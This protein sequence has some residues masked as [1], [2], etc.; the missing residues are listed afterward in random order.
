VAVVPL[1]FTAVVPV[2]LV[3]AMVTAVPRPPLLGLKLLIAGVTGKAVGLTAGPPGAVTVIVPVVAPA[4]TVAVI[5]VLE[6]TV[7]VV[8]EVPLKLTAVLPV[9]FVPLMV[10]TVPTGPLAGE[11]EVKVG[12]GA[13]LNV[14]VAAPPGVVTVNEPVT[15]PVG[16]VVL[17]WVSEITLKVAVLLLKNLT[18]VVPVKLV[19][20]IVTGRPMAP[21]DGDS[22]VMAGFRVKVLALVA[23]P[24]EFVTVMLPVVAPEGTIAVIE[25]AEF[26]VKFCGRTGVPLNATPVTPV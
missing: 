13:T 11:N 12:G 24:L 26:M 14:L 3:P 8:A 6:V 9:R 2:K 19:P 23:V 22:E 16:T 4:G 21:L 7:K 5:F 10:T 17:I 20:L 18:D 1:N 15:A 25:V